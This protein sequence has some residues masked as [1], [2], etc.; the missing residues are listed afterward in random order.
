MVFYAIAAKGFSELLIFQ[1]PCHVSV[2]AS[3]EEANK[4]SDSEDSDIEAASVGDSE[5]RDSQ[6]ESDTRY[7]SV[8]VF[9]C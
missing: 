9:S 5:A 3:F 1:Q 2:S 6:E 4:T 7:R 8:L